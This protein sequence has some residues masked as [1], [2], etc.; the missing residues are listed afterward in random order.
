MELSQMDPIG[1]PVGN[2][3]LHCQVND[4]TL[5]CNGLPCTIYRI[6]MELEIEMKS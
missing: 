1:R 5:P 2:S 3:A 6:S 4:L